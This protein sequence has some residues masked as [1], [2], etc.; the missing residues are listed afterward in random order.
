MCWKKLNINKTRIIV[1]KISIIALLLILLGSCFPAFE[2]SVKCKELVS[3]RGEKIYVKS[4]NWGVTGDKQVTIITSDIE[5]MKTRNDT[6]MSVH[7]L[8][9]F[10]Y[11]FESDTLTLI[12]SENK[13]YE[14]KER[15]KSI[16]VKY[17]IVE[18][19]KFWEM[20]NELGYSLP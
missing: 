16:K 5:K 20:K 7:I 6:A 1:K 11:H 18:F 19:S 3:S 12:F 8:E 13:T 14:I 2:D 4:I 15:F 17:T 9:P 10:L